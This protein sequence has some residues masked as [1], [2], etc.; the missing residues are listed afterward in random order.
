MTTGRIN[1]V[2][3]FW[4]IGQP[5]GCGRNHYHTRRIAARTTLRETQRDTCSIRTSFGPHGR[6]PHGH[7][8]NAGSDRAFLGGNCQ[9]RRQCHRTQGGFPIDWAELWPEAI[10]PPD[11]HHS[12]RLTTPPHPPIGTAD[13]AVEHGRSCRRR[14]GHWNTSHRQADANIHPKTCHGRL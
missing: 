4:A 12:G 13:A 7:G 2:T 14:S 5:H 6:R 10:G 8:E 9:G 3:T 1:Q 11:T